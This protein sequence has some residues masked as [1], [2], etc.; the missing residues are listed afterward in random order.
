MAL[1]DKEKTTFITEVG[2][3]CYRV[4][5]FR[6]KNTGATKFQL[7]LNP[8]KCT[9]E[10][11]VGKM[12]GFL[13]TQRGIEIDPGKIEAITA[14][15]P[16]RREKE[17]RGFLGK[18]QYISRFIN[19]LTMTCNPLFKLLR[20]NERFVWDD[21]FQNAFEKIKGYLKNPPILMPPRPSVPLILYLT[22][23]KNAMGSLLAQENGEKME[24]VVYYISKRMIGYKLNYSPIEKKKERRSLRQYATN[25]VL[26]AGKL[27][28]H[29]FDGQNM[30]CIDQPQAAEIME[31][32]HAGTCVL[33]MNRSALAKKILRFGYYWQNME[34]ECVEYVKKC[35]QYQVYA[36][37]KHTPVSLLYN[38]T[39][40]WP[41]STWGIDIIGKIYHHASNGH[42][43]IFVAID[44]FTK[45]VEAQSYKVLMSS[46]VAKFI[47]NNIIARY[48]VPQALIS[49]NGGHFRGEVLKV[50]DEYRIEHHKSS[51]YRPQTNG[52]VKI[53]RFPDDACP[54]AIAAEPG[55]QRFPDDAPS[56]ATAAEP[57]Y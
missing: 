9:F 34:R 40:P 45:W 32:V 22:V 15:P 42:E 53:R 23:T 19:K 26:L 11:T 51:P 20:K 33:N 21:A 13:I 30:L 7:R 49:H 36:N 44:Y 3:F 37:L 29:S 55:Y 43:F 54:A 1:K 14:M 46:H 25:Y 17:V 57:T 12:L 5:P 48:G 41:F 52:A 8:K 16:P 27:Y 24:V 38:M 4:M 39:S 35:H 47:R 50:L 10:V 2:I 56:A 31:K 18:I 28:R 6:K